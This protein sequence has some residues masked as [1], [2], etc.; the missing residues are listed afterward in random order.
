METINEEKRMKKVLILQKFVTQYRVDFFNRLKDELLKKNIEL[1][2][3]YGKPINSNSKKKDDVDIPW[4]IFRDNKVLRFKNSN[5]FWQ[6]SLDLAIKSE[7]VIAEQAN[8]LLTNYVLIVLKKL[9]K[10]KFAFW[11]HGANLQDNPH[12]FRNKFKYLF[13]TQSDHWFAYTDGV[14]KFLTSKNVPE[15]KITVVNN[16]IDTKTLRQQYLDCSEKSVLDMK[17]ALGIKS[18]KVAIYSGGIYDIKKIDFLIEAAMRIHDKINDFHLLIIGS[19]PDEYIVEKVSEM[20]PWIHYIGPKFGKDR[21]VYFKMASIFLLPGAVGLAI[22]DSFATETPMVT[23]NMKLHG[24]E[25]EYLNHNVNGIMTEFSV[26]SYSSK[27][28]DLFSHK[29][30]IAALQKGC[31]SSM[32]IYTTEQMVENFSKGIL[33]CLEKNNQ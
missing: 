7:L 13:L 10:F 24:P 27:V 26:D 5:L 14:K 28:I 32:G 15:K 2:L 29:D 16:A 11:G 18:E 9:F 6:P 21:V 33:Q 1:I 30:E 4:A 17:V 12:S 25:I 22:L 19:G 20:N 8:S 3:V 23:T 31:M